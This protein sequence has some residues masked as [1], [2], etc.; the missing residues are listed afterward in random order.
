[1]TG[2]IFDQQPLTK[3]PTMVVT[4]T[5]GAVERFPLHEIPGQ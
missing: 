4:G 2:T 3:G 1:V 5:I